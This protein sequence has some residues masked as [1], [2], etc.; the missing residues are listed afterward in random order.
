MGTVMG[1]APGGAGE[2]TPDLGGVGAPGLS[3]LF[4]FSPEGWQIP[5]SCVP[6]REVSGVS[7]SS[8]GT[9]GV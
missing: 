6:V 4:P 3:V 9:R 7:T 2:D 8:C 1:E 5:L